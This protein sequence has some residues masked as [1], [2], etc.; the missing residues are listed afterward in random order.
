VDVRNLTGKTALVTGAASGIGRETALACI[1][2]GAD[3][4]LCDLDAV[5]LAETERLAR[6]IAPA[7]RVLA[8][9]VDVAS[10]EAMRTFADAVHRAVPAVDLLVNNAGVGLGGGLLDLSLEDWRWIVD[11]N[12]MGVVHGCHFFV[13]RMVERGVGGHV[14]NVASAAGYLPSE[15]LAAYTATKYAV[16]GL[17]ESLHIELHRRGIGVSAICPGIINTPITRNAKL[18]GVAGAAGAREAMVAGYQRRD[19]GPERVAQNILRAVQRDRV[20]APITIESWLGYYM[21]RLAPW[22]IHA[23]SRWQ[24][25][26]GMPGV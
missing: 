25:R 1:R 9:R 18:R 14:V 8:E 24:A 2:R 12:L 23:L 6:A 26:R 20:I 22:A 15:M 19:Y 3:L 21:K 16:L 4:A 7:R 5:G 10:P 13:P 17:S 11:I